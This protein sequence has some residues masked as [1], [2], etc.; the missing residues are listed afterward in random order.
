MTTYAELNR[1]YL[2][3]A[4]DFLRKHDLTQASEKLWGTFVDAVKAVAEKRGQTLGTHRSIAE[5]VLRLEKEFPELEL[6]DAFRHAEGLHSNF[7]EDHLPEE[8]VRLS[9]LVVRRAIEKVGSKIPF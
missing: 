3:E 8:S 9:A 4:E 7:F 2:K 5:F 6:H 1:K